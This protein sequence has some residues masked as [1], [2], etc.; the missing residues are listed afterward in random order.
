MGGATGF[1]AHYPYYIHCVS[2][3]VDSVRSGGSSNAERS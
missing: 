3:A 2:D 1:P